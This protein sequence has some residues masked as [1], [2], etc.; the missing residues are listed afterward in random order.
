MSK[1]SKTKRRSPITPAMQ[2]DTASR[3]KEWHDLCEDPELLRIE[4]V[5]LTL[6]LLLRL[7]EYSEPKARQKA[8]DAFMEEEREKALAERKA[9]IEGGREKALYRRSNNGRQKRTR[10]REPPSPKK[11][12]ATR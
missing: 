1:R 10:D 7:S 2:P 4:R 5:R 3:T 12:K 9:F 11:T 6:G 8:F